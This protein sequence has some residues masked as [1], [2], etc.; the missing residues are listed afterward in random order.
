MQISGC[1]YPA[2]KGGLGFYLSCKCAKKWL[3]AGAQRNVA[4]PSTPHGGS[5]LMR[6]GSGMVQAGRRM[7]RAGSGMVQAG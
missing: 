2:G 7:M 6:A 3:A 4:T 1:S 5:K